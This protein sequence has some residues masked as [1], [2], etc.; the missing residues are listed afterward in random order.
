MRVRN[1]RCNSTYIPTSVHVKGN[2]ML[3]PFLLE[4]QRWPQQVGHMTTMAQAAA[5]SQATEAPSES[6]AAMLALGEGCPPWAYGAK[7]APGPHWRCS[8][9]G[10]QN[11]QVLHGEP[12]E[13]FG[14]VLFPDASIIDEWA[15]EMMFCLDNYMD[16]NGG[17]APSRSLAIEWGV[18]GPGHSD[19]EVLFYKAGDDDGM[20]DVQWWPGMAT[21]TFNVERAL[22][23]MT[24]AHEEFTK[25]CEAK[26]QASQAKLGNKGEVLDLGRRFR[27][28]MT[29][30]E[31]QFQI[32]STALKD[33]IGLPLAEGAELCWS[34]RKM[35]QF[36]EV[37][38]I[39]DSRVRISYSRDGTDEGEDTQDY[40]EVTAG[41]HK[42]VKRKRR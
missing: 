5:S 36:E 13:V 7:V 2:S 9:F 40:R 39:N 11:V 22:G 38:L 33:G 23:M 27:K 3:W 6:A 30:E 42:T 32:M 31:Q 18:P 34:I 26:H 14:K 28:Q 10:R 19:P 35:P 25:A 4:P 29:K 1:S 24:K 12:Q 17:W 41:S 8:G 21:A 20:Y 15:Q 37:V 16:P